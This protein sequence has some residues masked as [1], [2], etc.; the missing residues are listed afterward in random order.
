[1][2][3]ILLILSM[4]LAIFGQLLFKKGVG[5]SAL[6]FNI[7][8]I[9]STIFTPFV[10]FGFVSYALSSITWMFV[11]QRFSLSVAYP[12]M[13]LTY[14]FIVFLSYFVLGESLTL[15]KIFGVFIIFCGVVMVNK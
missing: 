9:L 15:T 2:K 11:L 6:E 5:L 12:S 3:Y 10:F 13:A 8:S 4:S 14:I 1:M 7:K